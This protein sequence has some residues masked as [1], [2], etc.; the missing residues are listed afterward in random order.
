MR[1]LDMRLLDMRQEKAV[2]TLNGERLLSCFWP[3]LVPYLVSNNLM[4]NSLASNRLVSNRLA[5][6]RLMS[7][8][9][10]SYQ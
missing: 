5:S 9:L 3:Y 6:N 10:T 7:N 1:Q 8:R 4:S 2:V